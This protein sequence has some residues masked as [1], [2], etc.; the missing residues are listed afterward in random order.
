MGKEMQTGEIWRKAIPRARDRMQSQLLVGIVGALLVWVTAWT[1]QRYYLLFSVWY[2][3]SSAIKIAPLIGT[4]AISAAFAALVLILRA[5]TVA[6]AGF[7][8][9]ICLVLM[10][11]TETWGHSIVRSGLTPLAALFVLTFLATRAGKRRKES[12]GLGEPRKGRT[13]AQVIANLSVA[14]LSVSILGLFVVL[15]SFGPF[16]APSLAVPLNVMCLAALV[17]AAADTVS[18]ELGQAFGGRPLLLFSMRTVEPGTDGAVTLFG[19]LAGIVAGTIVTAAGIWSL[20]LRIED[21]AI[22][23]GAGIAG[24]FFDSVLGATVERR[25]WLGNDLVNFSSTLFA[26]CVARIIYHWKIY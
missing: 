6:G 14:A 9:M 20:R 21:A 24:L 11:G 22:A 15:G 12:A 5:A 26:A 19:S 18:S 2:Q 7:G 23:L 3:A 13:V 17:E 10:S 25:G 4:I 16:S 1:L 8:G